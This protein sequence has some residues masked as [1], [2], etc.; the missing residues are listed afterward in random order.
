[1]SINLRSF[2]AILAVFFFILTGGALAHANAEINAAEI[3]FWNAVK[4]GSKAE[5]ELILADNF[6]YQHTTGNTYSKAEIIEIFASGKITVTAWGP[7]LITVKDYGDTVVS[8]GVVP[9]AGALGDSNYSG[10]LRFVDVWHR[11]A[12][13]A[14]WRLTHRNSELLP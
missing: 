4:S 12:T 1:M 11:S 8:Y 10:Q 9:V 3:R 2:T 6:N 7:P 5:L 14:E 13:N